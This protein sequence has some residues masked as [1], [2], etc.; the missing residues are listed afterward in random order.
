MDREIGRDGVADGQTDG[1][2]D[3]QKHRRMDTWMNM[4]DRLKA[5]LMCHMDRTD[6]N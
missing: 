5:G 4:M 6:I 3:G 2:T 1:L